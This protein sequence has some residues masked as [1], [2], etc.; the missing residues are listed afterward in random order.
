VQHLAD[1]TATRGLFGIAG[2]ALLV[3]VLLVAAALAI[4]PPCAAFGALERLFYAAM[5][6]WFPLLGV[7]L[8]GLR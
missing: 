3:T 8:T 4:R 1:W 2:W 7:Q 6:A 5:T